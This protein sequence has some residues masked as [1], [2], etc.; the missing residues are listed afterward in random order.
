MM[1]LLDELP[2]GSRYYACLMEDEELVEDKPYQK[3][4]APD[5]PSWREFDRL[6]YDLA[7][8]KTQLEQI[9][10]AALRGDPS[11]ASS[12]W[13]PIPAAARVSRHKKLGKLRSSVLRALGKG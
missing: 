5:S 12:P 13:V 6:A 2:M 11:K 7:Q 10:L 4:D 1:E 9:L 8:I 3:P